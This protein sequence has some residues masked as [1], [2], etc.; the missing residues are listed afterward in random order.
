MCWSFQRTG[1]CSVCVRALRQWRCR[2]SVVGRRA[3]ACELEQ[4]AR[5]LH[6]DAVREC[7]GGRRPRSMRAPSRT[8]S[9]PSA[10]DLVDR[11]RGLAQQ[12]LGRADARSRARRCAGSAAGP[13]HA[14]STPASNQGRL[15]VRTNSAAS[16]SARSAMPTS[17]AVCRSWAR[18]PYTWGPSND[19]VVRDQPLGRHD[20]PLEPDGAAGGGRCPMPVQ[21]STTLTPAASRGDDRH[22]A[23]GRARPWPG[24]SA[25]AR[26]AN[27]CSRTSRPRA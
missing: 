13:Q 20:D 17:I 25:S 8:S 22:R 26:A 18:A 1:S 2:S 11:A 16:P 24:P 21:S 3:G 10:F 5:S 19:P 12:R 15:V 7:L 23:C 6:R 4:R 27:R 14:R 9:T